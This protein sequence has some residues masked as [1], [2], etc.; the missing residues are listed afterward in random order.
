[1]VWNLSAKAA[2]TGSIPDP[3]RSHLPWS[4]KAHVPPTCHDHGAHVLRP[5][6]PSRP[7]ARALQQE[8]R[9]DHS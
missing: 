4:N 8:E 7:R 9:G 1:M 3:G 6:K 5:L 2:D